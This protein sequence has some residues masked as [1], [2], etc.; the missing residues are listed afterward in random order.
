M[1]ERIVEGGNEVAKDRKWKMMMA[2]RQGRTG[3]SQPRA[4]TGISLGV[5]AF[6]IR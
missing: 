1:R 5:F 2:A 3:C 6:F 4:D